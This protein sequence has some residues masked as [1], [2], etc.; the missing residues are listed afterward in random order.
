M[1]EKSLVFVKDTNPIGI[2]KDNPEVNE[3]GVRLF[4][5][6]PLGIVFDHRGMLRFMLFLFPF[7]K[8]ASET[9]K[10]WVLL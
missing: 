6:S 7:T 9:L 1:L 8:V 10:Y 3:G 4:K 5:N 2:I